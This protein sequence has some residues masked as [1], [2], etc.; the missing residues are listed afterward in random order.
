VAFGVVVVSDGSPVASGS[1]A[2]SC[3]IIEAS[4]RNVT[5]TYT[6]GWVPR[7][8]ITPVIGVLYWAA[9]VPSQL[10]TVV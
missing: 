10:V 1:F 5:S 8:S 2:E 7:A 4:L 6:P 3:P 9:S